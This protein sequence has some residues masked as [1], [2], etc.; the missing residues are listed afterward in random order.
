VNVVGCL[1]A[2]PNCGAG[3][4]TK[5]AVGGVEVSGDS[6]FLQLKIEGELEYIIILRT[7]LLNFV[8]RHGGSNALSDI[9]FS[10][11][12]IA[13]GINQI[14]DVR[15]QNRQD[16]LWSIL[17]DTWNLF[18]HTVSK[19]M[20]DNLEKSVKQIATPKTLGAAN[21]LE[22]IGFFWS[23][24][25]DQKLQLLAHSDHFQAL[26]Y[27]L[28]FRNAQHQ[29]K[30]AS[31]KFLRKFKGTQLGNL[32]P[33]DPIPLDTLTVSSLFDSVDKV[34]AGLVDHI[35]ELAGGQKQV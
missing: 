10:I 21:F 12:N 25:T 28:E 31:N 15:V 4:E 14:Q 2:C 33:L 8:S 22:K 20:Q 3:I 11:E 27:L 19:L 17:I 9:I 35:D 16:E 34:L 26:S 13:D 7:L 5:F 32:R 29:N 18:E 24:S 1:E 30:L 6:S 23:Q